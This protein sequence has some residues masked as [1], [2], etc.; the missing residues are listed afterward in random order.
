LNLEQYSLQVPQLQGLQQ[1]RELHLWDFSIPNKVLAQLPAGLHTLAVVIERPCEHLPCLKLDSRNT[2]GL[3]QLSSLQ[4]LEL[5]GVQ[6]QDAS[7]L[8]AALS[9][10]T[11]LTLDSR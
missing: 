11:S 1:L 10:L 4:Q 5:C 8:L 3:R 2:A 7:G 6:L 9:Q